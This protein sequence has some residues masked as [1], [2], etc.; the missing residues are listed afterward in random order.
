MPRIKKTCYWCGKPAT[1]REHVPPQNIYPDDKRVNLLTVPSCEEHNEAYHQLDERMRFYVQASSDSASAFNEFDVKT[2]RSLED[3]KAVGLV[4]KLFKGTRPLGATALLKFDPADYALYFEK[5][6]R[7]LHHLNFKT[8]IEGTFFM[9]FKQSFAVHRIYLEVFQKL[10]PHF[11]NPHLVKIPKVPHP[12]IFQYRYINSVNAA[13]QSA[14][15]VA[16]RF[17][18]DFEVMAGFT[19]DNLSD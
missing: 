4:K 3:D 18:G 10:A 17:Y 5:L 16:M 6:T 2:M 12:E 15:A 14:F 8:Q 13:K 9:A 11:N 1:S 19:S 7:G